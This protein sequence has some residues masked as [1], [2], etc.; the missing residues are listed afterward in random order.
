MIN[1]LILIFIALKVFIID[2]PKKDI[3][4]QLLTVLLSVNV[5]LDEI[6]FIILG[7]I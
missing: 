2:A 5:T 3:H 4:M 7:K 1:C 6:P